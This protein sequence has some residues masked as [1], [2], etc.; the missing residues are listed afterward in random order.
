MAAV[1]VKLFQIFNLYNVPYVPSDRDIILE[2]ANRRRKSS[3]GAGNRRERR[4]EQFHKFNRKRQQR[5]RVAGRYFNKYSHEPTRTG[6]SFNHNFNRPEGLSSVKQSLNRLLGWT[7]LVLERILAIVYRPITVLGMIACTINECLIEPLLLLCIGGV[8]I[9]LIII[10]NV[11]ILILGT[12]KLCFV[13][14]SIGISLINSF[15]LFNLHLV[16]L[17][18]FTGCI[19]LGNIIL[20]YFIG[21]L[22]G[23]NFSYS[24][25]QLLPV[26]AYFHY[27]CYYIKIAIYN[28][29]SQFLMSCAL[30]FA[31][32]FVITIPLFALAYIILMDLHNSLPLELQVIGYNIF[33]EVKIIL[34]KSFN[35]V[36]SCWSQAEEIH[37]IIDMNIP[38][39]KART[40]FKSVYNEATRFRAT[41]YNHFRLPN[42][43]EDGSRYSL[44]EKI[45]A[46]ALLAKDLLGLPKAAEIWEIDRTYDVQPGPLGGTSVHCSYQ[47]DFTARTF[48]KSENLINRNKI[49]LNNSSLLQTEHKYI[50]PNQPVDKM[51]SEFT[52]YSTRSVDVEGADPEALQHDLVNP[53]FIRGVYTLQKPQY[54]NSQLTSFAKVWKGL[55][56]KYNYGAF[57]MENGKLVRRNQMLKQYPKITVKMSEICQDAG[58]YANI[59]MAFIKEEIRKYSKGC[60]SLCGTSIPGYFMANTW[61]YESGHRFLWNKAAPKNGMPL[62]G[63]YMEPLFGKHFT[64]SPSRIVIAGDMKC[65]DPSMPAEMGKV[66]GGVRKLGFQDHV[67]SDEISKYIDLYYNNLMTTPIVT[68]KTGEFID[69]HRGTAMGHVCHSQ[70]NS[71]GL[72]AYY[73]RLFLD[74][75]QLIAGEESANLFSEIFTL[76]CFGD[77]NLISWEPDFAASR[78]VEVDF[79]KWQE[80]AKRYGV[81][82]KKESFG[83]GVGTSEAAPEEIS[84]LGKIPI[85]DLQTNIKYEDDRRIL[86]EKCPEI[87]VVHYKNFMDKFVMPYKSFNPNNLLARASGYLLLTA[88]QPEC[89]KEISSYITNLIARYPQLKRDPSFKISQLKYEDVLLRWYGELSKHELKLL[90]YVQGGEYNHQQA[91]KQIDAL[92]VVGNVLLEVQESLTLLPQTATGLGFEHF[93]SFLYTKIT[94]SRMVD[95][96]TYIHFKYDIELADMQRQLNQLNL[97]F[98][99]IRAFMS[100]PLSISAYEQ[101]TSFYDHPLRIKQKNDMM[102]MWDNHVRLYNLC[103]GFL[104]KIPIVNLV[105]T[106]C[107]CFNMSLRFLNWCEFML[108]ARHVEMDEYAVFNPLSPMIFILISLFLDLFGGWGYRKSSFQKGIIQLIFDHIDDFGRRVINY[109]PG[110]V[111]NFIKYKTNEVVASEV[112]KLKRFEESRIRL[113]ENNG[114]KTFIAPTGFGKSTAFLKFLVESTHK[115]NIVC[116]VPTQLIAK[117]VS[118]YMTPQCRKG[119]VGAWYKDSPNTKGKLIYSTPDAFIARVSSLPE[120]TIIC[121]DEAHVKLEPYPTLVETA[122]SMLPNNRIFYM[123]ATPTNWLKENTTILNPFSAAVPNYQRFDQHL[124]YF[125]YLAHMKEVVCTTNEKSLVFVNSLKEAKVLHKVCPGR[126]QIIYSKETNIDEAKQI[127][128]ATSVA[129][130]GVTF[131]DVS[132]V[133]SSDI[134]ITVDLDE[135]VKYRISNET[136]KQRCGRTGRTCPGKAYVYH[137]N[138]KDLGKHTVWESYT[139]TVGQQAKDLAL[140]HLSDVGDAVIKERDIKIYRIWEELGLTPDMDMLIEYKFGA[141]VVDQTG[142][143]DEI[144]PETILVEMTTG[145]GK[146]STGNHYHQHSAPC[147]GCAEIE[148][149]ALDGCNGYT[150]KF[151]KSMSV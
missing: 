66:L 113:F 14:T 150:C 131:P 139:P 101:Q 81:V 40:L 1:L 127:Y 44:L 108:S 86:G 61:A 15:F 53:D 13:T 57:G 22:T 26:V 48:N 136:L 146:T 100:D 36:K 129:D 55:E 10:S 65:F 130:A 75:T 72:V 70:D 90:S 106:A 105:Q 39:P 50:G 41:Y 103:H 2:A 133:Y 38:I 9:G 56:L 12:G 119:V 73:Y 71:T 91:N 20:S 125:A 92:S 145:K 97:R 96:F 137:H 94:G 104:P 112:N 109:Y 114:L 151:I 95:L 128:I 30:W 35:E 110:V 68:R 116:I 19:L 28:L 45:Q 148:C 58:K 149:V 76:D 77:D 27:S 84:F 147:A 4:V 32:H 51:F 29:Y 62:T 87:G 60:R 17:W 18:K 102:N 21:G 83:S 80:A 134:Q 143:D 121:F 132:R 144:V 47:T 43:R 49:P 111:I 37:R 99:N 7:S 6:R 31:W 117:S 141:T 140:F 122:K 89:H 82:L 120:N 52:P 93:G 8:R 138:S 23:I 79:D 74:T 67:Q 42:L 85:L 24:Y 142:L 107:T 5:I 78:G 126:S 16:K 3:T 54:E 64:G 123:T 11:I 46:S 115:Y 88:H 124:G 135:L 98:L 63:R 59:S 69:K 33:A 25:Y 118:K 34:I